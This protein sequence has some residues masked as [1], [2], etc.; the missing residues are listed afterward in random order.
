MSF[1]IDIRYK[2]ILLVPA[3]SQFDCKIMYTNDNVLLH[4]KPTTNKSLEPRRLLNAS[5]VY[6][7]SH[8]QTF[9]AVISLQTYTRQCK[10]SIAW[11]QKSF[12]LK[13]NLFD[14]RCFLHIHDVFT[15]QPADIT[16]SILLLLL[17]LRL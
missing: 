8:I 3:S 1:Y 12:Y 13:K 4:Y 11:Q 15:F 5:K 16:P 14:I 2:I 17:L 7:N 6:V 9:S 10:T